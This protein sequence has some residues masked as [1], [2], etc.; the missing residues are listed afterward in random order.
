MTQI[1]LNDKH[2]DDPQPGD[3]WHEMFCGICVI[4]KRIRNQVVLCRTKKSIDKDHWTWDLDR[5]EI[6]T[7]DD[8]KAW[9]SYNSIPG[10]WCDVCPKYHKHI[11][12]EI[13]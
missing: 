11:L 3:Y 9:L 4:L 12:K 2:L 6:M 7:L 13:E 1:E 10:C 5:L 8:F